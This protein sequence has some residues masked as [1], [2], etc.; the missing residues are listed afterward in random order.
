MEA[1]R[2]IYLP[3]LEL[4]ESLSPEFSIAF[5]KRVESGAQNTD[6][7]VASKMDK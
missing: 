7:T 6:A 2:Y 5:D 3:S 4:A 1:A